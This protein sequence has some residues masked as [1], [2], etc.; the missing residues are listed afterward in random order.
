M[1]GESGPD[2]PAMSVVEESEDG[3]VHT[4]LGV[5]PGPSDFPGP[6]LEAVRTLG[7]FAELQMFGRIGG[8]ALRCAVRRP[9]ARRKVCDRRFSAH[10]SSNAA[11]T[12]TP[13]P[14]GSITVEL[15]RIAP[16]FEIPASQV[17]ILDSP[18]EF[19]STLKVYPRENRSVTP[20]Q[21]TANKIVSSTV[22]NPQR[23]P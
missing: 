6:N 2:G 5:L 10:T 21:A 23:T 13:S 20:Y 22:K 3:E 16:R 7:T 4:A 8:Q 15:D 17:T 9:L 14:L 18:A 19:Y 1:E 11:P 12:S